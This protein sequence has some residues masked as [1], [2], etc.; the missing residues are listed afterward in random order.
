MFRKRLALSEVKHTKKY[1]VK[2]TGAFCCYTLLDECQSLDFLLK[3]QHLNIKNEVKVSSFIGND[4]SKVET[5]SINFE[6]LGQHLSNELVISVEITESEFAIVLSATEIWVYS[7]D[8]DLAETIFH[9]L[10]GE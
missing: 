9:S 8:K 3:A 1:I 4:K 6:E 10:W 5:L 7:F 2:E